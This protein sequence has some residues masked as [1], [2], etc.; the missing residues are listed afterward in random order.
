MDHRAAASASRNGSS[1]YVHRH[2]NTR[3]CQ[4][5]PP[6]MLNDGLSTLAD[7]PVVCS[8]LPLRTSY[9]RTGWCAGP[10]IKDGVR[11]QPMVQ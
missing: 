3:K 6:A 10:V 4:E 7:G 9:N 1:G 2:L 11:E 5:S 8:V